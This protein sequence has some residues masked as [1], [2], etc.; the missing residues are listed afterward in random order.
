MTYELKT[1]QLLTTKK[2]YS[3]AYGRAEHVVAKQ[4]EGHSDS[5]TSVTS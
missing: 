2:Q 1:K 3:V 4:A 5:T